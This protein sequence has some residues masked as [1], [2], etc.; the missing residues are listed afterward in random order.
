MRVKA[1]TTAI[2][3]STGM[4]QALATDLS[5]QSSGFSISS[6]LVASDFSLLI[7]KVPTVG[8]SAPAPYSLSNSQNSFSQGTPSQAAMTTGLIFDAAA[9]NVDGTSGSKET[10]ASAYVDGASFVLGTNVIVFSAG[11]VGSNLWVQGDAGTLNPAGYADFSDASLF[12]F[13]TQYDFSTEPDPNTVMYNAGGLEIISNKQSLFGGQSSASISITALDIT[14]TNF[15]ENGEVLNGEVQF[16]S[17]QAAMTA[18]PEPL[19]L[20]ALGLFVLVVRRQI[21]RSPAIAR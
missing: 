8:G 6:T 4:S 2:L 21:R 15:V 9:S 18:S 10:S 17:S 12:V 20:G 7:S 3:V 16:G 5:G 11:V 1:L 13:G 14:F 19:G